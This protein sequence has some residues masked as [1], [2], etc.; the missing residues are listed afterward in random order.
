MEW[1]TYYG[2]TQMDVIHDVEYDS[3]GH[4]Y[5][6]GA[7]ESSSGFPLLDPSG[8]YDYYDG[9]F[10]GQRDCFMSWLSSSGS[11]WWS[12]YMGDSGV[13][14][15]VDLAI[16]GFDNLYVLCKTDYNG[17]A[18]PSPNLIN[19]Y[20]A[21]YTANE[22][23]FLATFNTYYHHYIWGTYYGGSYLGTENPYAIA[24]APTT[25][26]MVGG[27]NSDN[28][29]FPLVI[30]PGA[31]NQNTSSGFNGFISEFDLQQVILA[32]VHN[33]SDPGELDFSVFPNPAGD[34]V[35]IVVNLEGGKN[36]RISILNGV[37]QVV[38]SDDCESRSGIVNMSVS[39]KDFAPGIY[40]VNVSF[41]ER[42]ISKKIIKQ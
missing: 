14:F 3:Y 31:Y 39:L 17:L 4:V 20:N 42:S 2:G 23:A 35:N 37:G 41:D 24:V 11:V 8:S 16:D 33:P 18:A 26:F 5:A 7:T 19:G 27:T 38:H 21:S 22:E 9:T 32:S 13:E 10:G 15:A 30:F 40:V 25:L 29:N 12:S 28:T 36:V 34:F 1:S 6:V